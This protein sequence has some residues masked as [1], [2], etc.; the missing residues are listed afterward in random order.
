MNESMMLGMEAMLENYGE[1]VVKSLAEKYD[2]NIDDALESL[3]SVEI[4]KSKPKANKS[5]KTK[6]D[7]SEKPKV[8]KPSMP[9]PFCGQVKHDWCQAIVSNNKLFTQ[10]TN[11]K[12]N[13][14]D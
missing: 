5:E 13:G 3:P 6:A 8:E 14:N 1:Q 2:F 11:A 7:K 4:E 9:L 12:V 10:C